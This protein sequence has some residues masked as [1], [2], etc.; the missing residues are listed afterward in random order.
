MRESVAIV[1]VGAVTPVGLTAPETAASVRAGVSRFME[2]PFVGSS[3]EPIVMAFLDELLIPPP[4]PVIPDF[5]GISRRQVRMLQ[6]AGSA[7]REAV[8]GNTGDGSIPV[9]LSV[10]EHEAGDELL[11]NPDLLNLLTLQ[12]GLDLDLG[13]SRMY[14]K[15]RAGGILAIS[16]AVNRLGQRPESLVLVGG[17]DS[18]FDHTLLTRLDAE[19]RVSSSENLDGFIPGEGA[20]FLLLTS[21]EMAK[22]DGLNVLGVVDGVASAVE[23][24]HR[25]SEEPY[26]GDGL[27][28]CFATLFR[29][30]TDAEPVRTV[31]AGF[32]GES[33][34]AKQWAV[35]HIRNSDHIC[36]PLALEHPADCFG[37]AG[38]AMGTLLV[39]VS[40]LALTEGYREG[41]CLDWCTSDYGD[42]GAVTLSSFDVGSN[43][44]E[45]P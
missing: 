37:D 1:G 17:V 38:A 36:E 28:E 21:I 3:L 29:E 32:N 4:D 33:Y 23:T 22:R 45:A 13:A 42:C 11:T 10:P 31:Y 16:D 40:A 2:T 24:G 25:Y 30:S 35:A 43:P 15:G 41:P 39:V 20:G 12:S 8:G 14:A 27:S 9:L 6:L 34:D 19:G 44:S 18:F 5:P 7:A 26:R